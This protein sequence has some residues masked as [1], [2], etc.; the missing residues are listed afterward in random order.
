MIKQRIAIV[1]D[2]DAISRLLQINLQAAGYDARVYDRGE[3]FLSALKTESYD[4][5]LLDWML[6]GMDGLGVCRAVRQHKRAE[7]LPIIMLTAKSDEID[8]VLGLEMGADDYVTKPFGVR[9]VLARVRA[10]LR[11][12]QPGQEDPTGVLRYGDIL[13]DERQRQVWLSGKGV[14]LSYK[15]YEL[16]HTLLEHPGWVYSR[17]VLLER[18]WGYEFEGETRTVDMHIANI[19]KKLE[20]VGH[21]GLIQTIRGAGYRLKTLEE[22]A[23]A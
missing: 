23:D 19:R 7:Q 6:P 2:E 21:K 8:K 17:E 10:Q 5:L 1:E 18:V 12:A 16:L 22:E 14:D 13:L 20:E 11:R 3:T 15:E 4:L 9:E